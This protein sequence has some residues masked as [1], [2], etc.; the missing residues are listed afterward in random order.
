M[1]DFS[2]LLRSGQSELVTILGEMEEMKERSNEM[3]ASLEQDLDERTAQLEAACRRIDELTSGQTIRPETNNLETNNF[4]TANNHEIINLV[5]TNLETNNLE[6]NNVEAN[7]LQTNDPGRT[8]L[9]THSLDT[10]IKDHSLNSVDFD[11]TNLMDMPTGEV[12]YNSEAATSLL[13][14][15][16]E[17]TSLAITNGFDGKRIEE[18]S[19]EVSNDVEMSEIK[20]RLDAYVSLFGK[21]VWTLLS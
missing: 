16:L 4:E 11:V 21:R 18:R 19:K 17:P 20:L 1:G 2:S 12:L 14:T 15:R 5:T 10:N 8:N 7:N 9:E 6:T 13:H 3:I